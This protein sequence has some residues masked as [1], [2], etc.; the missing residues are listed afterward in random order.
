MRFPQIKPWPIIIILFWGCNDGP[1]NSTNNIMRQADDSNMSD[2]L[3]AIYLDDSHRLAF[4]D[5]M[6]SDSNWIDA[7]EIPETMVNMHYN[8]LVHLFN[9]QGI[10]AVDS[11]VDFVPVHTFPNPVMKRLLVVV[12]TSAT[13]VVHWKRGESLTGNPEVDSLMVAYSLQ[14][15]QCRLFLGKSY[16]ALLTTREYW[17][18]AAI[19]SLFSQIEGVEISEPDG[20]GGDGNDIVGSVK[21]EHVL[22]DYYLRWDDCPAGCTEEHGWLFKVSF[23]GEVEFVDSRGNLISDYIDWRNEHGY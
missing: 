13:W 4:R 21:T 6:A 16:L 1:T 18:I 7:I 14:V 11:V 3:R 15:Q 10:A 23:S 20:Y 8:G 17:N 5:F 19:A 12:D 22:Y 2:S 9:A